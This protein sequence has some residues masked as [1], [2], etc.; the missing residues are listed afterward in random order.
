MF[1][2]HIPRFTV[3]FRERLPPRYTHLAMHSLVQHSD[4]SNQL[5]YMAPSRYMER[6]RDDKHPPCNL[7]VVGRFIDLNLLSEPTFLRPRNGQLAQSKGIDKNWLS[8]AVDRFVRGLYTGV[9]IQQ[10]D[11]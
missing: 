11:P 8:P 6:E 4:H 9:Y 3:P 10:V 5:R 2:L 1:C 7:V